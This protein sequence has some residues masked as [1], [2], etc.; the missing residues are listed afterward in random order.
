MERALLSAWFPRVAISHTVPNGRTGNT[1]YPRGDDFL[2]AEPGLLRTLF[3]PQKSCQIDIAMKMEYELTYSTW[4][5]DPPSTKLTIAS[6][7]LVGGSSSG[8]DVYITAQWE[9]RAD[10]RMGIGQDWQYFGHGMQERVSGNT[11]DPPR[12]PLELFW[13]RESKF[14]FDHSVVDNSW[15]LRWEAVEFEFEVFIADQGRKVV[16]LGFPASNTPPRIIVAL[17]R[18]SPSIPI[19]I[20]IGV[21]PWLRFGPYP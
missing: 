21:Q 19:R 10:M 7:L 12:E 6:T 2:P 18:Q 15:V 8:R 1:Y 11:S 20:N 3:F 5:N 16:R 13:G 4:P 17:S 14:K 9:P